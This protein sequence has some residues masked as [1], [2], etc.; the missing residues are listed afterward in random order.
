MPQTSRE[1][2]GKSSIFCDFPVILSHWQQFTLVFRSKTPV[3]R[4]SSDRNSL[5]SRLETH[6]K[7]ACRGDHGDH[8]TSPGI[9]LCGPKSLAE[10]AEGAPHLTR[11]IADSQEDG[12]TIGMESA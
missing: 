3:G 6:Q 8:E 12:R 4:Y 5:P 7:P 1:I 2:R 9:R 11:T 10:I